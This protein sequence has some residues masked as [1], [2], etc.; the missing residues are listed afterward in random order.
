MKPLWP[1]LCAPAPAPADVYACVSI[2]DSF[3]SYHRN[4]TLLPIKCVYIN[5]FRSGCKKLIYWHLSILWPY[6]PSYHLRVDSNTYETTDYYE[7]KSDLTS[8]VKQFLHW[9]C[10]MTCDWNSNRQNLDRSKSGHNYP[11]LWILSKLQ[12]TRWPYKQIINNL[13]PHE[14]VINNSMQKL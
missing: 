10:N 12:M 6:L 14:T 7:L 4:T 9:T 5:F 3:T 1:W 2:P 8:H 13:H 11:I